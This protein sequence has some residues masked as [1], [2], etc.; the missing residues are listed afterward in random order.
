MITLVVLA[1][2]LTIATVSDIR[3]RRIPNAVTLPLALFALA[4]NGLVPNT[5][6]ARPAPM[7]A[8]ITAGLQS[9]WPTHLDGRMPP[10]AE[11]WRS[12]LAGTIGLRESIL[13]FLACGAIMLA[14]YA[15]AQQGAG[16]TKLAAAI[17]ACAGTECGILC[18]AYTYALAGLVALAIFVVTRHR[19]RSNSMSTPTAA[20]APRLPLA[21]FL[22]VGYALAAIAPP[23]FTFW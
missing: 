10:N 7:N 11:Q 16:D 21:P 8:P 22:S 1:V 3:W 23:P 5:P 4:V 13:G 15:L 20:A 17:G 12:S 19:L 14:P 6:P 2:G 18:L 9:I